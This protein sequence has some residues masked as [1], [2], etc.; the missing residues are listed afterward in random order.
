MSGASSCWRSHAAKDPDARA[1]GVG[2]R[3]LHL[4]RAGPLRR[5]ER[6][7]AEGHA[8][9]GP[10]IPR[11]PRRHARRRGEDRAPRRRAVR[12]GRVPRFRHRLHGA[13]VRAEH[14]R[15]RAAD[16]QGSDRLRADRREARRHA[17]APDPRPREPQ[18]GRRPRAH[19]RACA[20]AGRSSAWK[21]Y[22]Q[23]GPD[24]P[25][26]LPE[27]PARSRD[28]REGAQARHQGRL[29]AQGHSVRAEELRAFAV[30]RHRRGRR[31]ATRT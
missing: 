27:R 4:R 22:T 2:R 14:V 30:R 3:G 1:G 25:R 13:V 11:L 16:D 10:R 29:R 15:G 7:V 5:S 24:G 26:V 8:A 21:T 23:Y 20:N 19:G 9:T 6:A 31:S 12:Q 17:A 28:D 18:P